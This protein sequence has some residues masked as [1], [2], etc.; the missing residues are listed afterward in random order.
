MSNDLSTGLLQLLKEINFETKELPK[1]RAAG[2]EALN[3]LVLVAQQDTGQSGVVARFLL[4]LYNGPRFLFN[5]TELR[6]LD[7]SLLDD[8]L[9]VLKMDHQPEVEVHE[10]FEHGKKIWNTFEAAHAS[11][12][13]KLDH[14]G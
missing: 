2:V 9:A 3:R 7:R 4:G 1:I 12:R 10:H 11:T 13:K 5:L 6:R 14:L 8:C